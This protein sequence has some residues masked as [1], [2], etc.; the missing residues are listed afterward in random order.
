VFE[1]VFPAVVAIVLC[2]CPSPPPGGT[3]H[4][5]GGSAQPD[6]GVTVVEPRPDHK[7][8]CDALVAHAIGLYMAELGEQRPVQQ[9]PTEQ[10]IAALRTELRADP[11]C[12]TGFSRDAY[13]CAMTSETLADLGACARP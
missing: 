11:A 12:T 4:P 6:A 3:T 10:E 8:E 13:R 9:L 5:R 2:A 7:Q 1:R